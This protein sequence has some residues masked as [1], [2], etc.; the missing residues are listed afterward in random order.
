MKQT[1]SALTFLLAQ[2]RAIFKRAYIKGI[3][4]A[5]I[6]T[7][8]L[9]AGQAQAANAPSDYYVFNTS[10]KN[11]TRFDIQQGAVSNKNHIFAGA[12]AGDKINLAPATPDDTITNG[13]TASGARIGVSDGSDRHLTSMTGSVWGGN[14]QDTDNAYAKDNKVTV[15][16]TATIS[17]YNTS[18]G[19]DVIGGRAISNAG[20]A[21][22]LGNKV[23]VTKTNDKN[24]SIAGQL[25]AGYAEGF[26]GA[27][28]EGGE[29]HL[30]G[31]AT[32]DLTIGNHVIVGH[33]IAKENGTGNYVA[34]NNTLELKYVD[35]STSTGLFIVGGQADSKDNTAKGSFS[36]LNNTISIKDST[37]SGDGSIVSVIGNYAASQN[38][39][40]GLV[41]VQ[42]TEGETS[43]SIEN[44]T[45]TSGSIMGGRATASGSVTASYNSVSLTDIVTKGDAN[46][47]LVQGASVESNLGAGKT[48]VL[49]ASGNTI[50]ITKSASNT[51]KTMDVTAG[52][53]G[54]SIT[55][56]SAN[57]K[58]Y[59]RQRFSRRRL[60]DGLA[61]RPCSSLYAGRF[62]V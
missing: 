4:S 19:G 24:I 47:N 21:Y 37:L 49:Q 27:V 45:L 43:V 20:I 35:A 61:L 10:A 9:A 23:Y 52:I 60:F 25:K 33:A 39:D 22:A 14:A 58:L 40:S 34:Q 12:L 7:A 50:N 36:A 44:T 11:W 13:D 6:L 57:Q 3:A 48:A 31:T 42:G 18:S 16:G 51:A 2:Y 30:S 26:T 1:S 15:S 32:Q 8:G 5:V 56:S 55:A 38:A 28:A 29:E 62:V 46:A 17:F 54:A 41:K 59:W 53:C